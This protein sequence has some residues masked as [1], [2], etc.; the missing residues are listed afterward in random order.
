MATDMERDLVQALERCVRALQTVQPQLRGVIPAQDTRWALSG[1]YEVLE[2]CVQRCRICG[3]VAGPLRDVC[4]AC[5][6]EA[7]SQ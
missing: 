4:S 7:M 2:R 6:D 1:A 3:E 5:E